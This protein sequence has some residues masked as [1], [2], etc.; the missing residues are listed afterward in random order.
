MKESI[1]TTLWIILY[2]LVAGS[3]LFAFSQIQGF[4]KYLFS[5]LAIY[6][7]IRFFRRY[8]KLSLRITFIVVA[9]VFYFMGA[10]IMAMYL[11]I[12]DNPELMAPP[13]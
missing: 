13:A 2:A 6:V 3:L 11:F 1:K 4:I 5:L 10:F 7:G 9:I 12:Q 8:E